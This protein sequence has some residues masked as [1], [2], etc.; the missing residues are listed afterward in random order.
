M[1]RVLIKFTKMGEASLLSHREI[2]HCLER[3][4]RRSELPMTYTSGY[5]PR[6]RMSYSP[7]LP[8]GVAA[9]AEYL[10]VALEEEVD[11][12]EV[13]NRMNRA[14]PVGVRVD[15]IQTLGA[16]M[17]RLS[18]WT[19]YGLYRVSG[20]GME[21]YLLLSL[22]GDKQGRLKDALEELGS[23]LGKTAWDGGVT[24]VGL[25]ASR[26]E[27]LE[28]VREDIYYYDGE[29]GGLEKTEGEYPGRA[30]GPGSG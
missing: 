4:L 28:D 9:E 12:D 17:P 14:L 27:V 1:K 20:E 2:M 19:R 22:G 23:V 8:L 30:N 13:R 7:A 24:R 15:E 26:D 25:Y 21:V 18:R 11:I 5:S 6:P 10:E 29:T 3:A 16:T